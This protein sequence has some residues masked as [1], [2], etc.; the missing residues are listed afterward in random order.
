MNT[1]SENKYE[2]KKLLSSLNYMYKLYYT[3]LTFTKNTQN[4]IL[5][6]ILYN[7]NS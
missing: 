5:K 7:A 6:G 4:I 3:T 1:Q 2:V